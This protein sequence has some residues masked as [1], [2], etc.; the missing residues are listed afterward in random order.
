M[1]GEKERDIFIIGP[2]FT[3]SEEAFMRDLKS[4]MENAGFTHVKTPLDIG[5]VESGSSEVFEEDL[6]CIE[7]S[8][9]VVA[10]LDG[11]DAGT[12][13]EIGYARAKGKMIVGIWTDRERRLD[14]FVR[15]LCGSVVRSVDEVIRTIHMCVMSSE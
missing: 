5:Y 4:A 15:W 8:D 11:M 7:R 10:I 14:P 3:T 12:M 2:F 9:V 13:C 6:R 1:S